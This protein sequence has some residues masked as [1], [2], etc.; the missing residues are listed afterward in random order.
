MIA[1]DSSLAA[2]TSDAFDLSSNDTLAAWQTA[3]AASIIA[4]SDTEAEASIALSFADGSKQKVRVARDGE[5]TSL[6]PEQAN[7]ALLLTEA[8]AQA[9]GIAR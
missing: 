4:A 3:N 1:S 8:Q 5:Q 2:I 6:Q 7:Y 9:L